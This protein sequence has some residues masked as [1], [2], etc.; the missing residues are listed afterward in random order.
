MK[1]IKVTE[2]EPGYKLGKDVVSPDGLV[3][4]PKDNIVTEK[5]IEY[6]DKWHVESVYV[7]EEEAEVVQTRRDTEKK[8]KEKYNKSVEKVSKMIEGLESGEKIYE[9]EV[10]ETAKE[11]MDFTEDYYYFFKLLTQLEDDDNRL[12]QH[13]I[14][15]G[16]YSSLLARWL[17]FDDSVVQEIGLTG[18]L[19]DMGRTM[20]ESNDQATSQSKENEELDKEH[21]SKGFEIIKSQTKFNDNVA[22][23]VLQHHERM[24]GEGFP[25]GVKGSSIHFYARI[26]AVADIFDQMTSVKF[27]REKRGVFKAIEHL[28]RESF[29]RLDPLVSRTF[30]NRLMDFFIGSKVLL[31][32]ESI[33]EV[34]MVNRDEPSRP[35]VKVKGEF[36]DL[37]KSRELTIEKVIDV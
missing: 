25:D 10:K 23:G 12:F 19:H 33:A 31:N 36:I 20:T 37:K 8:V 4:Y 2:L 22:K 34:I 17:D 13:S 5:I 21:P 11:L 3:L 30:M 18:L 32:D 7:K 9:Q 27:E 28:N 29:N 6:M 24:N 35:L 26:I 14:N 1:K 15:V 16:I